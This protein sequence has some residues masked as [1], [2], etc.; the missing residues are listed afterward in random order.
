MWLAGNRF[1]FQDCPESDG[2]KEGCHSVDLTFHCRIP[3]RIAK[4]E[5]HCADDSTSQYSIHI[6]PGHDRTG[7]NLFSQ[8]GD[9]PEQESDGQPAA[10]GGQS[11]D[12]PGHV[13][14][15]TECKKSKKPGKELKERCARWMADLEFI[16]RR[17]E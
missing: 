3:E 15:I 4:S 6:G 12:H 11:I 17:D 16:S 2:S 10:K 7:E 13:M 14:G 5:G 1:P 8:H 9:G